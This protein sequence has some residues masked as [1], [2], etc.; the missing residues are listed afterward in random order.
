MYVLLRGP[1]GI[2]THKRIL[3]GKFNQPSVT[4]DRENLQMNL[5]LNQ[6][7]LIQNEVNQ[8]NDQNLQKKFNKFN[9][10]K[11]PDK[12]RGTNTF[13]RVEDTNI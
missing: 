10:L 12:F 7:N 5:I 8:N 6:D 13:S 11:E 9:L 1:L 2:S 3:G 4:Y